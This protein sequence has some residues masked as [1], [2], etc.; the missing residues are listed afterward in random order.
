MN[1]ETLA[2][3]PTGPISPLT[4]LPIR[5]LLSQRMPA[6]LLGYWPL[7][8]DPRMAEVG[9]QVYCTVSACRGWMAVTAIKGDRSD[10]RIKT[11]AFGNS[12]GYGNN[13]TRNPP[14]WMVR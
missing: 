8:D 14:A 2:K 5:N 9:E 3:G 11:D 12:W 13:F 4:K 10:L 1:Y 6:P 7:P